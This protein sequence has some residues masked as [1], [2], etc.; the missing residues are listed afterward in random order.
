MAKDGQM[1]DSAKVPKKMGRP[2]KFNDRFVARAL[3]LAAKG[4]TEEQMAKALSV[5]VPAI[6]MWKA[7]N[8]SFLD[9]LKNAKNIADQMVVATLFQRACGYNHRDIKFF[10]TDGVIV[11][12]EYDKHVPPDVTACIFWLKNR[13]RK[14]WRDVNRD[15][16][17]TGNVTIQ[18]AYSPNKGITDGAGEKGPGTA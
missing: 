16:V 10:C 2:P 12:Q 11:S 13:Q 8:P 15:D 3:E 9:A 6:A 1:S 7:G 14:K 5:S 17:P 4:A 18:M